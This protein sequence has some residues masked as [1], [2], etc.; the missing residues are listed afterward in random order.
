MKE[1]VVNVPICAAA[2]LYMSIRV[3]EQ[4]ATM[5]CV[6]A[7]VQVFY[8]SAYIRDHSNTSGV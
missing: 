6:S 3:L 2:M 1:S 4:L 5:L 8:F 7:C